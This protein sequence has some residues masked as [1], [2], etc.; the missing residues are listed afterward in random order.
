MSGRGREQR[1]WRQ[2]ANTSRSWKPRSASSR[3]TSIFFGKPCG[4]SGKHASRATRLA[5]RRAG[6]AGVYAVIKAMTPPLPQGKRTIER[7]CRLAGV[8]RAG[9][10]R[11]WAASEPL[12]EE[13]TIRDA[14]QLIA[15]ANRRYGYR[16]VAQQLRRDGFVVN[17]K[18]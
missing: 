3:L 12:Q 9:Y 10:Y 14:V 16:R 8:N 6:G 13:T 1:I 17:H 11:H 18:R 7:M 5:G 4:E 15:L 2:L